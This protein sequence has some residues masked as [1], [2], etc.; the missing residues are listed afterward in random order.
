MEECGFYTV[1]T[2]SKGHCV[3][4]IVLESMRR[5]LPVKTVCKQMA[6]SHCGF[7]SLFLVNVKHI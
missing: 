4:V 3:Q 7:L 2:C 6:V 5:E 1:L